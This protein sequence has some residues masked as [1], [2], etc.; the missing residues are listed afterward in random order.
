MRQRR[1]CRSTFPFGGLKLDDVVTE[2][3]AVVARS[4]YRSEVKAA[5]QR[6]QKPAGVC[7]RGALNGHTLQSVCK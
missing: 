7:R 4:G 5:R 1:A 3:P 6:M 2:I